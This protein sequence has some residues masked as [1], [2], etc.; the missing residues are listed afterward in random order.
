M[1]PDNPEVHT[2]NIERVWREL[3]A[4]VPRYGRNQDNWIEYLGYFM[5]THRF[6]NHGEAF[7][8]FFLEAAKDWHFEAKLP[9]INLDP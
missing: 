7:H 5:F 4:K 2:Q 1:N 8:T 3:K 9:P 6:K